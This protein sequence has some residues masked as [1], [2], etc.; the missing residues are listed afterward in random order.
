MPAV[1]SCRQR[2]RLAIFGVVH[3]LIGTQERCKL[4]LE[5][6]LKGGRNLLAVLGVL[7]VLECLDRVLASHRYR[8]QSDCMCSRAARASGAHLELLV[9]ISKLNHDISIGLIGH[10]HGCRARFLDTATR[11]NRC[12]KCAHSRRSAQRNSVINQTAQINGLA[13]SACCTCSLCAVLWS[14][15][16]ELHAVKVPAATSS[17]AII[18]FIVPSILSNA[19][20]L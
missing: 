8:C 15:G 13:L 2:H 18:L 19:K 20:F 4:I 17:A 1:S 10:I 11:G 14:L 5:R 7:N 6:H 16:V 9:R 12:Q 3:V